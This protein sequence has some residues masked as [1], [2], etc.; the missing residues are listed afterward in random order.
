MKWTAQRMT[1][2]T[3]TEVRVLPSP[4]A[5]RSLPTVEPMRMKYVVLPRQVPAQKPKAA[6]K[7][8]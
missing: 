2:E 7:P 8:R 6:A 1:E 4:K 3:A 5:G